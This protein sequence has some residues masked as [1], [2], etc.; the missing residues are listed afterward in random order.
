MYNVR[1]GDYILKVCRLIDRKTSTQFYTDILTK[2]CI[3]LKTLKREFVS[4][5]TGDVVS[6]EGGGGREREREKEVVKCEKSVV[7]PSLDN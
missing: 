6:V 3:T 5:E 7:W 4:K 2:Q 1:V